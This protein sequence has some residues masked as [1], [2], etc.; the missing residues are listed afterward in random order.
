MVVDMHQDN[1][2]EMLTILL[3][4]RLVTGARYRIGILYTGNIQ[5]SEAKGF[6]RRQYQPSNGNDPSSSSGNCCLK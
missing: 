5:L 1:G 6:F 4:D 2:K 3:K